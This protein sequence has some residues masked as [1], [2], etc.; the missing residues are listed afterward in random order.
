MATLL[1]SAAVGYFL[2]T[3]NTNNLPRSLLD[4]DSFGKAYGLTILFAAIAA[5]ASITLLLVRAMALVR[6]STN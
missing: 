1:V 6:K 3:L 2:L 5:I 4:S